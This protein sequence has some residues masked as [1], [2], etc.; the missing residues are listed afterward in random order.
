MCTRAK[1]RRLPDQG[2][3][4]PEAREQLADWILKGSGPKM[5]LAAAEEVKH[6]GLIANSDK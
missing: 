2:R 3:E 4:A 5:D 6:L 1:T